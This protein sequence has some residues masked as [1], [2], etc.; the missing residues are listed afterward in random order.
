MWTGN[1]EMQPL[2]IHNAWVATEQYST[3]RVEYLLEFSINLNLN[4]RQFKVQYVD[5]KYKQIHKRKQCLI[6]ISG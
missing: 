6:W 1:A 4:Y 2:A 5:V 3:Y